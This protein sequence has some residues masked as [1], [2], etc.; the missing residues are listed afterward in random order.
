MAGFEHLGGCFASLISSL[1]T[2]TVLLHIILQLLLSSLHAMLHCFMSTECAI[3]HQVI[4]SLRFPY[5]TS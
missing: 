4:P 1:S 3:L 5:F 2:C